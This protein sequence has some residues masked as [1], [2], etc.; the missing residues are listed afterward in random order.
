M[1]NWG[2][3]RGTVVIPGAHS[4]DPKHQQ[5]MKENMEIF[6][7]VL[8]PDDIARITK[9][10]FHNRMFSMHAGFTSFKGYD[11]FA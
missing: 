6:D 3:Q 7:F 5:Y 10:D 11:I 4:I 2:V 1:L 9:L 8:T